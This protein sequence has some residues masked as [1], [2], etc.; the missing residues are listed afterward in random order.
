M[1]IRKR[2]IGTCKQK[3]TNRNLQT[4]GEEGNEIPKE[5]KVKIKIEDLDNT[6]EEEK[7]L[8]KK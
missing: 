1:I 7:K 4:E 6:S 2:Q 8:K 5:K 3:T